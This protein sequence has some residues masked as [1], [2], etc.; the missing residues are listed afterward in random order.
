MAVSTIATLP[1]IITIF[2]V[3]RT[4]IEGITLTCTKG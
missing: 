2:F 4:F 1:I 3:Q